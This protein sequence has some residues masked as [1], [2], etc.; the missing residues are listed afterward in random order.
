MRPKPDREW[1]MAELERLG[2][3]VVS[4]SR[5]GRTNSERKG[6]DTEERGAA[7]KT[8]SGTPAQAAKN[9]A[10]WSTGTPNETDFDSMMQQRRNSS[11]GFSMLEQDLK[12]RSSSLGLGT[13]VGMDD[14]VMPPHRPLVGGAS[15]A[16]YEAARADH[17]SSLA[18]KKRLS[19]DAPRR[20]SMGTGG[21]MSPGGL[22]AGGLSATSNQH[23]EMLKLVSYILSIWFLLA[24]TLIL[25]LSYFTNEASHEFAQRDSRDDAHDESIS[26]ATASTATTGAART[27]E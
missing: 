5:S 22:G 23:Y 19:G 25:I 8:E 16:A 3:R 6:E 11:I 1:V 17:Y 21:M 24:C 27:R 18:A 10:G 15:A 9:S 26:A 7:A 2:V 14:V 20:S 12:R 4:G 13:S